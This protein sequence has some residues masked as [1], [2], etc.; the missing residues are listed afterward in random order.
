MDEVADTVRLPLKSINNI[1]NRTDEENNP[2]EFLNDKLIW[3]S[4]LNI[5]QILDLQSLLK[6]K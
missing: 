4:I 3:N 5:R 6:V 2:V 1:T